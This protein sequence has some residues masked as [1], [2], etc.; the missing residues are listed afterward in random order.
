MESF[1]TRLGFV[2]ALIPF[3]L[4][5]ALTAVSG[6]QQ[7]IDAIWGAHGEEMAVIL[8]ALGP[9]SPREVLREDPGEPEDD[10]PF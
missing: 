4:E 1:N 9:E 10:I 7:A 3:N 2:H 5:Q 6:L 8:G